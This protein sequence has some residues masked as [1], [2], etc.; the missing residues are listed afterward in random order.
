MLRILANN[1]FGSALSKLR[2]IGF[3]SILIAAKSI[4]RAAVANEFADQTIGDQGECSGTCNGYLKPETDY[5][6]V[7][8]YSIK[9]F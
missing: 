2:I 9:Y 1:L 8:K 3:G 5:K 6:Y 4:K 7:I